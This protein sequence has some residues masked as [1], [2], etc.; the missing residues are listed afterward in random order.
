MQIEALPLL[1]TLLLV[2]YCTFNDIYLIHDVYTNNY[3][4]GVQQ[5]ILCSHLDQHGACFRITAVDKNVMHET[6]RLAINSMVAR[7]IRTR[8]KHWQGKQAL[9][10]FAS[11]N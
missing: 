1:V 10:G 4:T 7:A 3:C 5:L 6:V 2:L 11:C 8:N 9:L